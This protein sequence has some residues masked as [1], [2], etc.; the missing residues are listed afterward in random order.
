MDTES[1]MQFAFSPIATPTPHDQIVASIANPVF[2]RVFTDH[3]ATVRWTSALGWHD[4]KIEARRPFQ[5]DPACAV[6]HYAQE[7]FEGMKAY[8]GEDNSVSLFRPFENAKRFRASAERMSMAELPD[9][10]FVG[11]VESLVK[12]DRDWVPG[13]DGSLYLRPFMFATETF[14]GVR[15]SSEYLF[16]VIASPVGPY[17]KAGKTAVTVWVSDRYTRAALGGTGAAKC[18]GNYAAGLSAQTEA[19]ANGCDQVVFLD[20]AEHKWIEELGGMNV[21]FVMD[22]GSLRTPPLSGTILPGITR[23]SIIELAKREGIVVSEEPYAF[24]TWQADA[25]SGRVREAFACGTAAV[26]TAIG[27]VRHAAGEFTIGDGG[28][29]PVTQRIRATLTGIQR[30]KIADSF[31][32]IHHVA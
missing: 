24:E 14:L 5:I 27:A 28:E 9:A 29:G 1:T 2:G 22:D 3:M 25:I 21:F 30:G 31:G 15:A 19:S 7:I 13:G 10:L 6:L 23:A 16:C 11:A 32:W 20:A 4:A 12:V 17:F 18:G 26:V 8:R